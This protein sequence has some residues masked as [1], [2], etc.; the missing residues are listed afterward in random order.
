M[1][2]RILKESIRNSR[3]INALS[4]FEEVVFYRL[5]TA[6]DDF[7]IYYA[8][9]VML[10]RTLFPLRENVNGT[11]MA[12]AV[13]GLEAAGLVRRYSA[14]DEEWLQIVTWEKHQRL[15]NS[16]RRY[17][18]PEDGE[19][20]TPEEAVSV[21]EQDRPEQDQP[22]QEAE[23]RELPVA[24]LPLNDDTVYGVTRQQADEYAALY[25]GVDV[26]RELCR[27]R[28]W[29]LANREKRKSRND[30]RRFVNG[31]LTR[32]QN[33]GSPVRGLLVNEFAAMAAAAAGAGNA[34]GGF[35]GWHPGGEG[36]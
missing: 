17:P 9:P 3:Q 32:E 14:A 4:Y 33:R 34:G 19:T 16:R 20:D 28:E 12:E 7:G 13:A 18:G 23:V 6:A 21:Q 15:R 2:N 31:W 25:P 8:D 35:D 11:M 22:E 29:C 27:M 30:I 5:V 36:Q 24:E 1:G 26:D 10:A